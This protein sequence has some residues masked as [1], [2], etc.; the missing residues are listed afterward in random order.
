PLIVFGTAAGRWLP[1]AG[2]W[3]KT[4]QAVFGVLFLGL[5]IWMLSRFVGALWVMLM[6]GVLL[7]A[8]GVYMGALDRLPPDGTGWRRLW[9]A[10]GL[11]LLIFGAAELVGTAAGSRNLLAPLAGLGGGVAA[12]HEAPAFDTVKS[13]ADLKQAVA[14]AQ[15][16]GKPVMLDF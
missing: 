2:H 8:S 9:K 13:V 16:D 14:A 6:T 15:A 5:A 10:L 7:V 4:V 3:M 11:V 12:S 1:R